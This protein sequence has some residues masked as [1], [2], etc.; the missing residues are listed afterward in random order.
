MFVHSLFSWH[1]PLES[2]HILQQ[3]AGGQQRLNDCKCKTRSASQVG[4]VRVTWTRRTTR[5]KTPL[6]KRGALPDDGR[7][8]RR[9]R[10]VE[11]LA[12]RPRQEQ[13]T[14]GAVEQHEERVHH[15]AERRYLRIVGEQHSPQQ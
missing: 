11:Q 4:E 8:L 3:L 10:L 9:A 13:Q 12:V 6:A 7:A 2:A 1:P 5:E 14:D 15:E